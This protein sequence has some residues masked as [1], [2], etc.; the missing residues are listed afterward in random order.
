MLVWGGVA[1]LK[2]SWTMES[3][4]H[5]DVCVVS[6]WSS[7]N[8]SDFF[9][10]LTFCNRNL[11]TKSKNPLTNYCNQLLFGLTCLP[12]EVNEYIYIYHISLLKLWGS[13][14]RGDKPV[15]TC[16][17]YL[18]TSTSLVFWGSYAIRL[19]KSDAKTTELWFFRHAFWLRIYRYRY[20]FGWNL[21]GLKPL[22][23]FLT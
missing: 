13:S 1:R 14:Y 6:V 3:V 20:S 15:Y 21:R 19:S 23:T 11:R 2:H 9:G 5:C 17:L 12:K 16:Q 7:Q 22:Q 18:K 8:S 10:E 4:F